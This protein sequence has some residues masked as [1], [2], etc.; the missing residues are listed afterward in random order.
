LEERSNTASGAWGTAAEFRRNRHAALEKRKAKVAKTTA[1]KAAREAKARLRLV[2]ACAALPGLEA[3]LAA[4]GSLAGL[5][6]AELKSFVIGRGGK[7][8]TGNKDA[9]VAA[10]EA[11]REQQPTVAAAAATQEAVGL[12]AQVAAAEEAGDEGGRRWRRRRRST[13]A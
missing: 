11:V 1:A 2:E 7:V 4:G 5:T 8:P 10:A 9:L 3:K 6:V 13:S 12:R